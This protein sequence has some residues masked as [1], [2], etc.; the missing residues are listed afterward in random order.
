[1]SVS[2]IVDEQ[3]LNIPDNH[4]KTTGC[5]LYNTNKLM[6]CGKSSNYSLINY[7]M[8]TTTYGLD[9]GTLSSRLTDYNLRFVGCID[10]YIS[11]LPIEDD[12]PFKI[13]Y[14]SPASTSTDADELILE[15]ADDL[16]TKIIELITNS[17]LAT[18]T[19]SGSVCYK[20]VGFFT[21]YYYLYLVVQLTCTSKPKNRKL[22]FIRTKVHSNKDKTQIYLD[23][24]LTLESYYDLYTA[25]RISG[26]SQKIAK[27]MVFSGITQRKDKLY[28]LTSSGHCKGYLWNIIISRRLN[29]IGISMTLINNSSTSETLEFSKCPVGVTHIDDNHLFVLF[30]GS[31]NC[32]H[33]GSYSVLE[34]L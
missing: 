27:K 11:V 22:F 33:V 5:V 32:D 8:N 21:R 3:D 1:M 29:F 25:S 23:N 13:L 28:L 18:C 14:F 2:I 9:D 30:R 24:D 26:L 7:V 10:K 15:S 31:S 4:I 20:L 6:V 34:T 12:N 17:D 16:K 19:C